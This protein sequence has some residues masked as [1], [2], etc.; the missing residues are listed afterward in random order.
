MSSSEAL[1]FYGLMETLPRNKPVIFDFS[2]FGGMGTMFY[3]DFEDFIEE[4]PDVY[5]I[6]NDFSIKQI[7]EIG[8]Q[9]DRIFNTRE[10]AIQAIAKIRNN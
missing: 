10:D 5:W 6:V 8:V 4:N 9:K 1:E 3:D 7:N 2:N